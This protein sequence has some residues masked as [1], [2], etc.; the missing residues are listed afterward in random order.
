[1]K[2]HLLN[3][4]L[5]FFIPEEDDD[6]FEV[7]YLRGLALHFL[8][9]YQTSLTDLSQAVDIYNSHKLHE[10]PEAAEVFAHIKELCEGIEEKLMGGLD[11]KE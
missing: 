11:E 5:V 2:G 4:S 3:S 10:D 6:V 1:M 8:E 7:W 9:D